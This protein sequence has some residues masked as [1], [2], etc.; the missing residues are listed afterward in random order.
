MVDVFEMAFTQNQKLS[1]DTEIKVE[2]AKSV[3]K[4]LTES[5][6]NTKEA[7]KKDDKKKKIAVNKIK[8]TEDIDDIDIQPAEG[9]VV[10]YSDEIE[11][12]MSQEEIEKKAEEM[13]GDRICKCGICGANYVVDGD[14]CCGDD[15]AKTDEVVFDS[16]DVKESMIFTED[17]LDIDEH[18]NIEC[19]TVCPVCNSSEAQVEVGI[20]APNGDEVITDTEEKE[21]DKDVEEIKTDEDVIETNVDDT[22]EESVK[23]R[24]ISERVYSN[25]ADLP[26]NLYN[27]EF[28]E[29][30]RGEG[31]GGNIFDSEFEAKRCVADCEDQ[32]V[33]DIDVYYEKQGDKYVVLFDTWE[34]V[35]EGVFDKFKKKTSEKETDEVEETK[36]VKSKGTKSYKGINYEVMSDG[37]FRLIDDR[38]HRV[39]RVYK[40]EDTIKDI[41]D[42]EVKESI[43]KRTNLNRSKSA[44]KEVNFRE[45]AFN[46]LLSKFINE[47][48]DNIKDIKINRG[49]SRNGELIF[50]GYVVTESGKKRPIKFNSVGF[51]LTEG[52]IKIKM[53]ETGP[54]TES[55][56]KDS[57]R[58]PFVL[59]CVVHN[60]VIL[61]TSL[62][63]NYRI[64]QNGK[65]YECCGKHSVRG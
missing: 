30:M 56:I 43:R 25:T 12:E 5:K 47:N 37:T 48:Y 1:K 24:N 16:E 57:N 10:V 8:F 63:Y 6:I 18:E 45:G 26:H 3:N 4:A 62:K 14:H 46:K 23:K 59:E 31:P 42:R 54:F 21:D 44:V 9:I 11:P 27:G 17:E 40:S 41:I 22:V 20:I 32:K 28:D 34:E 19:D 49:I 52:K 29:F 50:N 55:A 65:L 51:K 38:G 2:T 7:C 35:F 53:N 39:D 60:N 61:P 13:I 64:K 33:L 15:C 36:N 58:V